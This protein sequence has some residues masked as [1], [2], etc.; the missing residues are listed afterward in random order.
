MFHKHCKPGLLCCVLGQGAFPT[1][2]LNT[3]RSINGTGELSG[4]P[5]EM[6]GVSHDGLA[7]HQGGVEIFLVSLCYGNRDK[8][9]RCG[10]YARVQDSLLFLLQPLF[11]W[12]NVNESS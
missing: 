12:N 11:V 8:F 3:R 4:K 5:D 9:R 1:Q 10:H 6:L 7:S 2:Y